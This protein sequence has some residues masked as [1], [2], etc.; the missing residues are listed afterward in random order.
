MHKNIDELINQLESAEL[1]G[2]PKTIAE[3]FNTEKWVNGCEKVFKTYKA[4]PAFLDGINSSIKGFTLTYLNQGGDVT[5]DPSEYLRDEMGDVIEIGDI[6]SKLKNMGKK[7]G[8]VAK[9]VAS[10]P[11]V[12]GAMKTAL[13]TA[14]NA[15]VPGSG[16][17]LSAVL[18]KVSE[19][20]KVAKSIMDEAKGSGKPSGKPVIVGADT[21][22]P[23]T[24]VGSNVFT[25]KEIEE[26][27]SK[28]EKLLS[29]IAKQ[30]AF[31]QSK[32]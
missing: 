22:K 4:I 16:T 24:I 23:N 7:V 31:I 13:G 1:T 18:D 27:K 19:A 5:L 2:D 25:P 8:N 26:L 32:K 30:D 28:N 6:K 17:A 10:N 21:S 3:V 29:I 12:M 14:L 11:V 9:K 20:K 15:V